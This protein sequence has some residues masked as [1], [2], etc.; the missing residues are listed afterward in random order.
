MRLTNWERATDPRVGRLEALEVA[1]LEK[2]KRF[3][4]IDNHTCK[5]IA[6]VLYGVAADLRAILRGEP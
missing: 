1:C 2:A 4:T 5:A 3:T 6:D